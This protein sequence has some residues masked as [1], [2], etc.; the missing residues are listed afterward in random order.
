MVPSLSL[1]YRWA[2]KEQV[3]LLYIQPGK[4]TQNAS[5]ERF[6]RT[7][8]HELLELNLFEDVEHAQLLATQWQWTYNKYSSTL[9]DWRGSASTDAITEKLPS[10][11]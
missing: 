3:T 4:P 5:I 9:G 6:N 11:D 1:F 10:F 7:A 2:I 8:R